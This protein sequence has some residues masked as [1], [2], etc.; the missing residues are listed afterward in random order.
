[1][2]ITIFFIFSF[3]FLPARTVSAIPTVQHISLE[4]I[5]SPCK[6]KPNFDLQEINISESVSTQVNS[7]FYG[8]IHNIIIQILI[9]MTFIIN[10]KFK[11]T[12]FYN[13][14]TIMFISFIGISYVRAEKKI[15]K[16]YTASYTNLA[17]GIC[18]DLNGGYYITGFYE[19]DPNQWYRPK[20]FHINS[21][22]ELSWS[23]IGTSSY[24][25]GANA[26]VANPSGGVVVAGKR[27]DVTYGLLTYFGS[28]GTY[29]RVLEI[30]D[31]KEAFGIC[32][33][34]ASNF[35]VVGSNQDN[36]GYIAK[37]LEPT[38][39]INNHLD[40]TGAAEIRGVVSLGLGRFAI[41]GHNNANTCTFQIYTTVL[42]NIV[43]SSFGFGNTEFKCYGIAVTSDGNCVIVGH[44]DSTT[45]YEYHAFI[46]KVSS[47]DGTLTA[48][49]SFTQSTTER[50]FAVTVLANGRIA[51]AG[52]TCS[53]GSFNRYWI[54]VTDKDITG[55]LWQYEKP[56]SSDNEEAHGLCTPG[57]DIIASVGFSFDG[58]ID[59][60]F[61]TAAIDDCPAGYYFNGMKCEQ[62]AAGKVSTSKNLETCTECGQGS[63]QS[64]I[65][66]TQCL[67]CTAGYYQDLNGQTMCKTCPDGEISTSPSQISCTKCP[68][69]TY[70]NSAHNFCESCDLGTYS[71]IGQSSCTPCEDGTYT[72][73]SGATSCSTCSIGSAP[74]TGKTGCVACVAG[75]YSSNGKACL[76]CPDGEA[77][78]SPGQASCTP[79]AM[80]TVPASDHKNCVQCQAGFYSPSAGSATCTPCESNKVSG[81][82]ASGCYYCLAGTIASFDQTGC[83][84]CQAGTYA[85]TVGSLVC[86]KCDVN[87]VSTAGASACVT[88][89]AG[90]I[91]KADQTGCEQ[92]PAGTYLATP[93][94]TICST[95]ETYKYSPGGAAHC[96]YCA[97]GNIATADHTGC[98]Q[99]P[100][101]TYLDIP[102]LYGCTKCPLAQFSTPGATGCNY[103][104]PGQYPLVDQSG[105]NSCPPGTYSTG[106]TASCTPCEDGKV[107]TNVGSTSCTPC[108]AGSVPNLD[109][110]NCNECPEGEYSPIDGTPS[111]I[112]CSPGTFN[113]AVGQKTCGT[114]PIGYVNNDY[115]LNYCNQCETNT[116]QNSDHTKCIDCP[117]GQFQPNYGADSCVSCHRLCSKC[118]G[119][120]N[121]DCDECISLSAVALISPNTCQCK[122]GFYYD[123]TALL[124]VNLCA[125]CPPFCASC[126]SAT[127]CLACINKPG[128][129]SVGSSCQCNGFGYTVATLP[130]FTLDC[131]PCH[132]KC[133][134]CLGPYST[135][136]ASCDSKLHLILNTT[137][138]TCDCINGYYLD[139]STDS[140]NACDLSCTKCIGPGPAPNCACMMGDYYDTT[141]K[142]C[143]PCPDPWCADCNPTNPNECLSCLTDIPN[144]SYNLVT[145]K[146]TCNGGMFRL[147]NDCLPCNI[148][149]K[150][151]IGPNSNDCVD[152][153]C[154]TNYF[155][156]EGA[157]NNCVYSCDDTNGGYYF[158]Q[159]TNFCKRI[160]FHQISKGC[161]PDCKYCIGPSSTECTACSAKYLVLYNNACIAQ[162]PSNQYFVNDGI[163]LPC[164]EKCIACENSF[165]NCIIGCKSPYA[166]QSGKCVEQ[167]STGYYLIEEICPECLTKKSYFCKPCTFPCADCFYKN[168]QITCNSCKLPYLYVD[169]LCVSECPIGLYATSNGICEK[170]DKS[171]RTCNG[172]F[173]TDCIVCNYEMGYIKQATGACILLMCTSGTFL[174]LN[175]LTCKDC[176]KNCTECKSINECT[177]CPKGATLVKETGACYDPC[178]K[179][180][181]MRDPI[182]KNCVGIFWNSK[183]SRNMW[184]WKKYGNKSM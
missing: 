148:R 140:C 82:G 127:T 173:N 73:G 96:D 22:G 122:A 125:P 169:G 160:F 3:A 93:G 67:S 86:T 16:V 40:I 170:C 79:C 23:Q 84:Q 61:F 60:H 88:C 144:V 36:N 53:S 103:C 100:A 41:A 157:P 49:K 17:N 164:S 4:F 121:V 39:E 15:N 98:E 149:C 11:M 13:I 146:C 174:D 64:G 115:R 29:I 141:A 123:C 131:V 35:I 66:F 27:D 68:A 91:P 37:V 31:M 184:R 133:L 97:A 178:A 51:A 158:D 142:Q 120:T 181:F 75:T 70:Q 183:I 167:C 126:S 34:D 145:K 33:I 43:D 117:L 152:Y 166:F 159:G 85:P 44:S 165:E 55:V 72:S 180:G 50:L 137:K 81:P 58:T 172:P 136:C 151:C 38:K 102:G 118:H 104:G 179:L 116:Y 63:Y 14:T 95:C 42:V 12:H 5:I 2:I 45:T 8:N 162:C 69:G 18:N 52:Y 139:I 25:S 155:P 94:D 28:G 1:M 112:P 57:G 143:Y 90:S 124:D 101:G 175:S 129:N 47:A 99:C 177:E 154:N 163:C 92:C 20:T 56:S 83:V 156:L 7:L 59:Y 10:A 89:S 109:K 24:P 119:Y 62:C 168:G 71:N 106:G 161:A 26:C 32:I 107:S 54:V 21:V 65:D 130:D 46:L 171:C 6:I 80:G 48:Q 108:P 74:N 176:S 110:S 30:S 105:C 132:P 19:E 135:Q 128:I 182:T 87:K 76:T 134:T 9:I 77:T 111:C 153:K 114:C 147:E 138:N 113:N 78:S 150:E